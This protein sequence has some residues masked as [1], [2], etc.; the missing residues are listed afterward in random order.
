MV[1]TVIC[2]DA[3]TAQRARSMGNDKEG[4]SKSATLLANNTVSQSK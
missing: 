4:E 1:G 3:D 2:T